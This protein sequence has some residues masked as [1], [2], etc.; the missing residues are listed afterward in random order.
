MT[1]QSGRDLVLTRLIPAPPAALYR[2]W[3]E[4]ALIKQW[5]APKP[6]TVAEA[7]TEL[8][9]GGSTRIVMRGPDGTEFASNGVYLELV[10]NARIVFTDAYTRAWEPAAKP[11]F[12]GVITFAPEGDATRYTALARHWTAEDRAAHEAMGFH[13]GWGRCADQLADLA[14]RL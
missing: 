4:P 1:D 14:A 10:E 5:F 3:T 13:D 8:R 7:E 9:P 12:T 11:F 2:A 6:Y